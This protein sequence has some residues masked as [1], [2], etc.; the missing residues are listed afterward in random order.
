MR[1][2]EEKKEHKVTVFF[3]D[4]TESTFPFY[5]AYCNDDTLTLDNIEAKT[6]AVINIRETKYR[7]YEN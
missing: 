4:G 6:I 1:K 2:I 5:D 7:T 3:K